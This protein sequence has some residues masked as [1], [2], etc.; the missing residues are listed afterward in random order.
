MTSMRSI[1]VFT[2]QLRLAMKAW[3]VSNRPKKESAK[4]AYKIQIVFVAVRDPMP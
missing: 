1:A 3:I 4:K 2:A